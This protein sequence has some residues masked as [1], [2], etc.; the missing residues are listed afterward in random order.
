MAIFCVASCV[1]ILT[2]PAALGVLGPGAPSAT[3]NDPLPPP[4]D[5]RR[6]FQYMR[7]IQHLKTKKCIETS[8]FTIHPYGLFSIYVKM[9]ISHQRD[10]LST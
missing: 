7:R 1:P 6:L 3:F 9:T 5:E 8:M 4:G 10:S 2:I